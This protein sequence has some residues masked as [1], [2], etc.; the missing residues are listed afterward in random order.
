MLP[1][2]FPA[3]RPAG[4]A[5]LSQLQAGPSSKAAIALDMG[6]YELLSP[7][8]PAHPANAAANG[9]RQ[10]AVASVQLWTKELGDKLVA[11][12]QAYMQQQLQESL[13]ANEGLELEASVDEEAPYMVAVRNSSGANAAGGLRAQPLQQ[14][15]LGTLHTTAGSLTGS[16]LKPAAAGVS[17]VPAQ[18]QLSGVLVRRSA[19]GMLPSA[20]QQ[21]SLGLF[22]VGAVGRASGS[23][24]AAASRCDGHARVHVLRGGGTAGIAR[25]QVCQGIFIASQRHGTEGRRIGTPCWHTPHPPG[26]AF[27][28]ALVSCPHAACA[29]LVTASCARPQGFAASAR[30]CGPPCGCTRSCHPA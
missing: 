21:L 4:V 29:T 12:H 6:A 9:R 27:L 28:P 17:S 19:S 8:D 26:H 15:P 13:D 30:C 11:Q 3:R 10:R 14:Q 7:A 2:T 5:S 18:R 24:T 23:S 20:W 16:S 1:A 22:G 25:L